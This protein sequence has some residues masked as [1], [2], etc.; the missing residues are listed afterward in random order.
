M[1]RDSKKSNHQGEASAFETLNAIVLALEWEIDDE[2]MARFAKEVDRLRRQYQGDKIIYSF[3]QLQ[4]SIGKYIGERRVAAHPDSIQLLH[5]VFQSLN[6]V[7]SSPQMGDVEKKRI[8]SSEIKKFKNLKEK[9]LKERKA[10][11][12]TTPRPVK[13]P[14]EAKPE[15]DRVEA[16]PVEMK[17]AELAAAV[18]ELKRFI[19]EELR[20]LKRELMSRP[21]SP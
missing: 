17:D 12:E 14:A 15:P 16:P 13:P 6:R 2:N 9:I 10:T 5:S 7:V 3:L 19:S 4:G 21:P 18:E 8:L 1:K 11:S 20:Q